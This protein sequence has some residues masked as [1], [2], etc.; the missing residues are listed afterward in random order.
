MI[1]KSSNTI[2][3][4]FHGYHNHSPNQKYTDKSGN[5][6]SLWLK[7]K[8]LSTEVKDKLINYFYQGLTPT[9]ALEKLKIESCDYIKESKDRVKI[10]YLRTVYYL[11]EQER[12]IN[13]G[14]A[15][16]CRESLEK[17]SNE[18]VDNFQID[19]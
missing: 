1:D 19:V 18:F 13:F 15:D 11:F 16:I 7:S 10:P 3:L 2:D 17:F 5:E 12:E 9:K 14:A 8:R 6:T 4:S